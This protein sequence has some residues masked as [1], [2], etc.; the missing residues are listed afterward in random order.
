MIYLAFI[1]VMIVLLLNLLVAQMNNTYSTIL[2]EAQCAMLLNR[3][4]I[5]ARVDHNS[6]FGLILLYADKLTAKLHVIL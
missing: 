1:V 4:W 3:A 5:I 6:S 2:N